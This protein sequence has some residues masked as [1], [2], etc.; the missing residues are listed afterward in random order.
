MTFQC[1]VGD[2]KHGT[3]VP[4][5]QSPTSG[6]RNFGKRLNTVVKVQGQKRKG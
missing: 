1:S 4:A 5:R 6:Q 3:K 2:L